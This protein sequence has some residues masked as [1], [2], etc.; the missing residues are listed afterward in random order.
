M[1]TS[2]G[3]SAGNEVVCSAL[4]TTAANGAQ[5]FDYRVVSADAAQSDI[6]DLV[7]S[8]IDLM[9]TQLPVTPPGRDAAWP[10]HSTGVRRAGEHDADPSAPAQPPPTSVAVAYRSREQAQV[11]RSAIGKRRELELVHEANAALIYLRHTGL[12]DRYDTIALVDLGATGMSVT[13][14]EQA[15]DTVL[16]SQRTHAIS[17]TAIDELIYHHL[18]DAHFARRGTRPNRAM[19]INRGRAAKEHLSVAPAVT[20]DHVAGRPLKLTRAD[21]EVL[22]G[23]LLAD[24]AAYVA[25]AFAR[26]PRAPE[27]VALVGGGANIPSLAHTLGRRL[28]IPVI[29]VDDPEAVIA[30]GAALV[31]D[32]AQ[33]T[34][35][36]IGQIGTESSAST[37]TKVAGVLACAVVVVGLII[38]YGIKTLAPTAGNEVSPAGT[39]SSARLPATPTTTTPTVA[40]PN[41]TRPPSGATAVG[42]VP[43][44][45]P[46][47]PTTP[48]TT[49]PDAVAPDITGSVTP[50]TPPTLRPDPNLPPI[51][52]PE[53]LG[54][55]LDQQAPEPDSTPQ[56]QNRQGPATPP[57][58]TSPTPSAPT[59]SPARTRLPFP[60][61]ESGSAVHDSTTGEQRIA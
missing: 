55:L 11:I 29:T 37:F 28:D 44:V 18:V 25:A 48:Q 47:N 36:P 54:D 10:T 15:D 16:H 5:S 33:P 39:T 49:T 27:A 19:L 32:A 31:A 42:P 59:Q 50:S 56:E 1:R 46:D 9:T 41:A 60:P 40:E 58:I 2:L 6:G 21:F 57:T 7:A 61:A 12:T 3:I 13:V 30:K 17:G 52:F 14:A 38:G 45:V 24:T 22:I 53:L 34:A 4:V 23:G 35:V 26:S 43:G 51:P 8:S 20:I